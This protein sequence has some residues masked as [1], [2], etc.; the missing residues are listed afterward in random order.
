[1][2]KSLFKG[3]VLLACAF[4]SLS[5]SA[6][7]NSSLLN[8]SSSQSSAESE[9][10][11]S[12][13]SSGDSSSAQEESSD[14]PSQSSLN[15][16]SSSSISSSSPSSSISS[17]LAED[18]V[19]LPSDYFPSYEG[20]E[21]GKKNSKISLNKVPA[22]DLLFKGYE[23]YVDGIK[24]DVYKVLTNNTYAFTPSDYQR[25]EAGVLIMRMEGKAD[26]TVR[27]PFTLTGQAILRP[28]K[29]GIQTKVDT[30]LQLVSFTLY[31][32]G[33]YILEINGNVKNALH[34]FIDDFSS[35]YQGMASNANTV[36]F[37]PGLHNSAND[38]HIS[39][40]NEITLAS[41]QTAIVDYGAVI[42]GRF[43]SSNSTGVKIIGGGVID[44]SVF[45]RNA[46]KGTRLIPIELNY[47]SS[48]TIQGLSFL[49]PA[50]WCLNLY[51]LN[52]GT[53]DNVKIISS[54]ANG[55]GVSLQ[56]CQNVEVK[57][58]F[59][60]TFD[61]S[62]VVKNYPRYGNYA[63]E[64]TTQHINV[65]DCLI[66]TDLAQSMEIGYETIGQV[67]DDISFKDITIAHAFHHAP[68]SIHN[69]NNA[70][71]TNVKFL[72]ITIE[73]P[74]MGKGDGNGLF[75]GLYCQF[76][77]TWSTNWKTT[78]LGSVDG[79][80]IANVLV[81]ASSQ[82]MNIVIRGSLDTRDQTKHYIKNVTLSDITLGGKKIDSLYKYID[83]STYVSGCYFTNTNAETT[84]AELIESQSKEQAETNY[85][86]YATIQIS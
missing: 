81:G 36:Y 9:Q 76:S 72:N 49:D 47:C 58:C 63:S 12:P 64:G 56:S 65:H 68:L 79:V 35:D 86:A 82:R 83:S 41:N 60:R 48:F 80:Q 32:S 18:Y 55:D 44:G 10:E 46:T 14:M 51:Y 50:G 19:P 43:V 8:Q 70:N 16:Q 59:V 73:D 23:V 62:I 45:E 57:N 54:R 22:D 5:C 40:N 31:S 77:S 26:F 25:D 42:R 1:M 85:S 52:S 11:S 24:A 37:G 15:V 75:I 69:A 66:W 84:G 34:I 28:L 3:L 30:A 17:V 20:E 13:V 78:T 71:L 39:A 38:S 61:D 29:H 6:G 2:K 21:T 4:L 74:S 27:F 53:V 67:M 7:V 33:E